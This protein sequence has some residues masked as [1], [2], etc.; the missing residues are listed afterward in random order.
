[1]A[2]V[3]VRNGNKIDHVEM[4]KGQTIKIPAGG[5]I[6]M[7]DEDAVLFKSQFRT[8]KF[9]KSGR[10]QTLESMKVLS[11]EPIVNGAEKEKPVAED[12]VCHACG[13]KAA[14]KA[15]LL[16]HIRA[17]HTELMVDDEAKKEMQKGE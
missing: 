12:F 10:N 7:E 9:D 5:Y 6:E 3:R 1:M 4:F 8:P 15:G 13:K 17:N 16:A 2:K 14:N 11:I